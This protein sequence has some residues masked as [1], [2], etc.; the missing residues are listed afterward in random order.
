MYSLHNVESIPKQLNFWNVAISQP[1]ILL[2]GIS[3]TLPV[4]E[5][6]LRE[7]GFQA[8]FLTALGFF[9]RPHPHPHT[10]AAVAGL[11]CVVLVL[12]RRR[13]KGGK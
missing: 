4:P 1:E 13:G 10:V 11:F 12:G 8:V 3:Q 2:A 6:T 9:G 5:R 7:R